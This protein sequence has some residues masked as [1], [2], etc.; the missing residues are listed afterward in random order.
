MKKILIA[1]AAAS[2][3]VPASPAFADDDRREWRDRDDRRYYRSGNGIRFV[4]THKGQTLSALRTS[5]R[6]SAAGTFRKVN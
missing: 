5:Q 1:V 6:G 2:L 3:A 4:F